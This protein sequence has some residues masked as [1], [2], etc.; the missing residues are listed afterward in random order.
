MYNTFIQMDSNLLLPERINVLQTGL[1]RRCCLLLKTHKSVHIRTYSKHVH[2][3]N[4]ASCSVPA[5]V[6]G[7]FRQRTSESA[8]EGVLGEVQ[9]PDSCYSSGPGSGDTFVIHVIKEYHLVL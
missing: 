6:R 8:G 9:E 4:T 1:S 3:L 5:E 7:H 2:E